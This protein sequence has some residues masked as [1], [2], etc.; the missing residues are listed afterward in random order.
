MKKI[1]LFL[2]ISQIT[3]IAS[4]WGQYAPQAPLAGHE[5]IHKND[6]RIKAWIKDAIHTPGWIQITDTAQ[7]K[8][9]QG[10]I[11]LVKGPANNNVV[12]LGDGG[13]IICTFEHP[14]KNGS[15][16]DFA[17]FENGFLNVIDGNLAFLELAFVEVSSNGVDFVRFPAYS[18]TQDTFQ[19]QNDSFI[20]A[21]QIHNL[22][23]K[24]ILNYGT[25][26]DLEE[27][28]DSTNIDI[29]NITHIKIIDIVGIIDETLGSRD[30]N[31]KIIN[32]PFPTPF[33]S[34]GFDLNAIAVLNSTF[35][36]N[37]IAQ[38]DINLINIYPIPAT[39]IIKWEMNE[40]IESITVLDIMGNIILHHSL[41]KSNSIPELNIS[42]LSA[43]SYFI[44]FKYHNNVTTKA[45]QKI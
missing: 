35:E 10:N 22:A 41:E 43:N 5:G 13:S 6:T 39:D 31:S 32:D 36:P 25:P 11:D 30:A 42:H 14:I 38:S 37:N 12:S 1:L 9:V 23:G 21:R 29:N 3:F 16:P 44:Q 18:L 2:F 34:S 26:F 19:I 40:P 4:I 7:G 24:Y 45:F 27:L 15:G 28:K 8:V 17:V 33:F 20:D